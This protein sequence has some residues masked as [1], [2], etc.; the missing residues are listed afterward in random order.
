VMAST[1]YAPALLLLLLMIAS[2]AGGSE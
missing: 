1:D 2:I